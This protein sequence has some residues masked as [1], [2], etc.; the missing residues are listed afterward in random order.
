MKEI[1]VNEENQN[2]RI[3]KLVRKYL[4]VAPLSFIY[5]LFRKKDVKVNG[6]WVKEN[7][8]VSNNDVV[9][10]Y[11]TDEQISDF[12]KPKSVYTQQ[13]DLDIVYEDKNI[14]IINKEKGMLVQADDNKV[15]NLTLV[16]IV[17]SYLFQNGEFKND[18]IAYRPSPVHRLDRNTSGLC[19]FAKNLNSSQILMEMFRNRED[20][21]KYYLTL[22]VGKPKT[23]KGLIDVPLLKD[24]DKKFVQVS[25]YR[26]GAKQ[27][28]TE[29]ELLANN[30]L[31]SL[32]KV[33]LLTGRTHQIRVHMAYN[34]TPIVGDD[35]YGNFNFNKEFN[36]KFKYENQFL[37]SYKICF[38]NVPGELSY[39]SN[40]S[41]VCDFSQ[42]ER[43]ILEALNL[44][45]NIN[46][47]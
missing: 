41:F 28:K 16:D 11:V 8:I 19:I 36:K 21:N 1:R 31:V 27:A 34:K 18:G 23:N 2:Q 25:S 12:N 5:K 26:N 14:L 44:K 43:T 47:I 33:H 10:I 4:N 46:N 42:K 32:L 35:K 22:V 45:Y 24:E 29:Y 6:H 40:K 13:Y 15:N 30:E 37:H 9:K 17:Q 39:L 38:L 7:Y 3:D 20:I